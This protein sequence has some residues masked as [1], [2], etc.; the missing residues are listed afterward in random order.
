MQEQSN[1]NRMMETL[2]KVGAWYTFA[3]FLPLSQLRDSSKTE[4]YIL[5]AVLAG[6][7]IAFAVGIT[8]EACK[9]RRGGDGLMEP[10]PPIREMVLPFLYYW[11][12]GIGFMLPTFTAYF[13][14]RGP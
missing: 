6:L 7:T 4:A 1:P 5:L 9:P 8:R 12:I 10:W 3:F 11:A 2:A 13:L 14:F